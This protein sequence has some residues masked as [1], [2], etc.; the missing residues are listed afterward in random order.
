MLAD[1]LL[2]FVDALG[3]L[4]FYTS[5]LVD[6]GHGGLVAVPEDL[7]VVLLDLLDCL[8]HDLLRHLE[9]LFTEFDLRLVWWLLNSRAISPLGSN[10]LL[11]ILHGLHEHL[12]LAHQLLDLIAVYMNLWTFFI[13]FAELSRRPP[14]IAA[15]SRPHLRLILFGLEQLGQSAVLLL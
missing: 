2:L 9:L 8:L 11:Q 7:N 13:V 12:H 3:E 14:A 4:F 6:H 1:S 10:E 5:L 15:R